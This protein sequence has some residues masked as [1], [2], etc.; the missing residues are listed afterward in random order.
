[1]I[2]VR[3]EGG[4]GNQLFQYAAG[5][6]L[7]RRHN[8][9]L[10]LDTSALQRTGNKYTRRELDVTRFRINSRI[11]KPGEFRRISLLRRLPAISN[12]LSQW[13]LYVEDS[14]LFNPA[15]NNL[16]DT[17]YLSGYWQSFRYFSE[18][19]GDIYADLQPIEELSEQSK[20]IE[21]KIESSESVAIHVRRGDYVSLKSAANMHGALAASYYTETIGHICNALVKPHFFVFSD[22]PDWCKANLQLP[23]ESTVYIS[24]NIGPAAWQDLRLMSRCRHNIIA[25]S[26]FSWWGAWLAD[27]LHG[28]KNRF[29]FA[30][31]RWFIGQTHETKDRFPNHWKVIS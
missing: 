12:W 5:R 20:Y 24:H 15:F 10:I 6:A 22:D 4:L 23:S 7:A 1:M 14:L 2:C 27:Q 30:P 16:P 26:S 19:A 25:N 18:I 29:V 13:H 28:T 17:T 21:Q 8:T 9:D 31:H 3:L 11:S